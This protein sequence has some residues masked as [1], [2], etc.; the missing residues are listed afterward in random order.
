MSFITIHLLQ[1]AMNIIALHVTNIQNIRRFRIAGCL[2][3]Q[4]KSDRRSITTPQ[5]GTLIPTHTHHRQDTLPVHGWRSSGIQWLL[6]VVI[7]RR[8]H[9]CIARWHSARTP[10]SGHTQAITVDRCSPVGCRK[11]IGL[12]LLCT[13][14][15]I[16]GDHGITA[17]AAAPVGRYIMIAHT[18]ILFA[19]RTISA[20]H[21]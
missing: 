10:S 9:R 2:R 12:L 8:Q 5:L 18:R 17:A 16:I 1:I 4:S 19:Q 6:L 3:P 11:I 15:S 14:G 21:D 13:G 7:R 20:Q